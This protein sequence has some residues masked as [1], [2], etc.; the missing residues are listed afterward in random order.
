MNASSEVLAQRCD[1]RM[2]F[3]A[4]MKPSPDPGS[5]PVTRHQPALAFQG[6]HDP[7]PSGHAQRCLL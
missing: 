5:L 3:N 2:G 7:V 6:A 4:E 1:W